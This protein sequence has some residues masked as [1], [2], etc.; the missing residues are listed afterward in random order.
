MRYSEIAGGINVI[1][2]NEEYEVLKKVKECKKLYKSSIDSVRDKELARQLVMKGVLNRHKDDKGLY[3]VHN[4][5]DGI[6]RI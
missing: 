3:F 2:S 4:S 6:W 5:N 1:I